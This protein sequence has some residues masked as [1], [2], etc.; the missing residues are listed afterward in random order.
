[1]MLE[2][3]S[4]IIQELA[5][6]IADQLNH[7]EDDILSLEESTNEEV[8][9]RIFRVFHSIKG[10]LSM[11]GFD[12]TS[13]FA[14]KAEDVIVLIRDGILTPEQEIIDLLLKTIDAFKER[15]DEIK[16]T[17][18]ESLDHSNLI[19]QLV[20]LKEKT[21]GQKEEQLK[22]VF[23]DMDKPV[24][25]AEEASNEASSPAPAQKKSLPDELRDIYK[26]KNAENRDPAAPIKILIVEDE[27]QSRYFMQELLSQ[28]GTVFAVADGNEAMQAFIHAMDAGAPYDL[29]CLD[30][31]L[32]GKNGKE[33]LKEIRLTERKKGILFGH[34]TTIIMVTSLNDPT[35]VMQAF[36]NMCNAYIVKPVDVNEVLN[37]L[38][39]LGLIP[40]Q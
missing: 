8:I 18:K 34:G 10:N 17:E 35:T 36:S 37:K 27:F 30:I 32:P 2:Q 21:T 14:H 24:E 3:D 4:E 31:Q 13:H 7:I 39:K 6:E 33:I 25:P 1:M 5:Q 23:L 20:A 16:A 28:F 29:V 15:I 12:K 11:V 26:S 19:E 40:E 22:G 38:N 9:N